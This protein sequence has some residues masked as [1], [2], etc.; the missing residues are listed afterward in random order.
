MSL[1][2]HGSQIR[3]CS[4]PGR[5]EEPGGCVG[6]TGLGSRGRAV[7]WP[8]AARLAA[9]QGTTSGCP[10]WLV[11]KMKIWTCSAGYQPCWGLHPFPVH[12]PAARIPV[13]LAQGSGLSWGHISSCGQLGGRTNTEPFRASPP[14]PQ[15]QRAKVLG[16][17]SRGLDSKLSS[18]LLSGSGTLAKLSNRPVPQFLHL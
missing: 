17:C 15:T 11:N 6:G 13:L 4:L 14:G 7:P 5:L 9:P 12:S 8:L 3:F 18:A 1:S 10:L 2:Q 16:P